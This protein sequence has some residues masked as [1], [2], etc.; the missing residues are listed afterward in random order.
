MA[1]MGCVKECYSSTQPP[2]HPSIHPTTVIHHPCWTSSVRGSRETVANRIDEVHVDLN[3]G[4]FS[5]IFSA[6]ED[7][8]L[9]FTLFKLNIICI[10]III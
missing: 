9:L 8:F 7:P 5:L 6:F 4:G 10:Y 3:K 1:V 2:T